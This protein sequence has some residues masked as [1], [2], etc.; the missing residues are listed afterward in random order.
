MDEVSLAFST[1]APNRRLAP[2][3]ELLAQ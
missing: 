3:D 2:H 1:T